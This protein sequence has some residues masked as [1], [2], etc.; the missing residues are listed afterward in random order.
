MIDKAKFRRFVTPGEDL[1][2]EAN[3]RSPGETDF[4]VQSEVLVSGQR[5][6]EARIIYHTFADQT[7]MS[8]LRAPQQFEDWARQMFR[9]LGGEAL[10]G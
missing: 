1:R 9:R 5:V 6:A 8:G 4:E 10:L 2:I 7:G 3:L